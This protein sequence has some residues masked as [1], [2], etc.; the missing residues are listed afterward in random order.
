MLP[1]LDVRNVTRTFA[2]AAEPVHALRGVTFTVDPGEWVAITGPSG[3]GK[4]TLL[5]VIS[6]LDQPTSGTVCIG[7]ED[8]TDAPERALAQIRN[9]H[10]GI[11]FQSFHLIPTLTA[12]E[13]VAAPLYVGPWKKEAASRAHAM[14]DRVGLAD[15]LDHRPHQLSGGQQQRVAI[16]R[17]LVTEPSVVVADEPTGNLDTATGGAVLDLFEELRADLGLTL[18]VVTHDLAVAARAGR[19]LHLVDG[20]LAPEPAAP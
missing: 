8:V 11:V 4:S 1:A 6:A 3:S 10:V 14:L 19:T 18:V 5:G 13:N 2:L 7:G 17:A 20:A 16:A 12:L 9:R 15:R